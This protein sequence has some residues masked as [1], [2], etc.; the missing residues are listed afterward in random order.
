MSEKTAK[1]KRQGEQS[2]PKVV[3]T[4][5]IETMSNGGTKVTGPIADPILIM[6]TIGK[7]LQQVAQY[8]F[9]QKQGAILKAEPRLVLPGRG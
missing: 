9:Q 1:L 3:F 5:T 7:A 8:Q 2:L 6:D 4:V